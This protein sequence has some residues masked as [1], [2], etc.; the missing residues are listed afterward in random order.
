MKGGMEDRK[1]GCGQE[2]ST[3]AVGLI[4]SNNRTAVFTFGT[5]AYCE[6]LQG[7]Q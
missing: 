5:F 6:V 1:V 3:D 2:D 7:I 4:E